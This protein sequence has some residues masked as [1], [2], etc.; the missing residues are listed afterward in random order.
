MPSTLPNFDLNRVIYQLR[1]DVGFVSYRPL[2]EF[3]LHRLKVP[4]VCFAPSCITVALHQITQFVAV[5]SNILSPIPLVSPSY[6]IR[7]SLWILSSVVFYWKTVPKILCSEN[8]SKPNCSPCF[9]CIAQLWC[10][11][12]Y[13]YLCFF[14]SSGQYL[15]RLERVAEYLWGF[16]VDWSE[17][18]FCEF[19]LYGV[20]ESII[21]KTHL[22]LPSLLNVMWLVWKHF[23]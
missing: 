5:S 22:P 16:S 20:G 17:A 1:G 2:C 4:F 21:P 10:Q 19:V 13:V 7:Q 12:W 9:P 15:V 23:L 18:G 6:S 14:F 3:H 8:L 11:F